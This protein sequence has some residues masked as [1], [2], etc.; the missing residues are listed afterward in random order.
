VPGAGG[1]SHGRCTRQSQTSLCHDAELNGADLAD[2]LKITR[3]KRDLARG[4]EPYGELIG[5]VLINALI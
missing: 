2:P 4:E 5:A 3:R 1:T